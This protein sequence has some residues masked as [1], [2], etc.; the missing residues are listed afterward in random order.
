[1][2]SENNF[3]AAVIVMEPATQESLGRRRVA[4]DFD[5]FVVF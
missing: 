3:S 4:D 5:L 2:L 1:M